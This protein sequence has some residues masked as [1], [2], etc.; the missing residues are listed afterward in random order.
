MPVSKRDLQFLV[1]WL[2]SGNILEYHFVDFALWKFGPDEV[3]ADH[4]FNTY[5]G[6]ISFLRGHS[7]TGLIFK[8]IDSLQGTG[9]VVIVPTG[10]SNPKAQVNL[11]V[12]LENPISMGLFFSNGSGYVNPPN[13]S[14]EAW[15]PINE[16]LPRPDL[17]IPG[18]FVM[19]F[20]FP[21]THLRPNDIGQHFGVGFRTLTFP[22]IFIPK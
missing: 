21:T 20:I 7:P 16:I 18:R 19:E 10:V 2:G 22:K 6:P 12:L 11:V 17:T 14:T 8:S 4:D 13:S 5:T 9:D 3:Q 15:D 1:D